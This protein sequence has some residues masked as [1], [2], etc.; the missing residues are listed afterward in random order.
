[1]VEYNVGKVIGV[2]KA[3]NPSNILKVNVRNGV[4]HTAFPL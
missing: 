3:G 2:D 4:I 1:M